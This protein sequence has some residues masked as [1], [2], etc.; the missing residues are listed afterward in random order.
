M[1]GFFPRLFI[2]GW[3]VLAVAPAAQAQ[4]KLP[5][6]VKIPPAVKAFLPKSE[7]A[8]SEKEAAEGLKE[9]LVQGIRSGVDVLSA[10][11]GF[12]KSDLYRLGLPS[13]VRDLEEKINSHPVLKAAFG[14]SLEKLKL[15]LNEAAEIAS[16]QAFPIFQSAVV[17]LSVSDAIGIVRGG[18]NAA[19]LYLK[20]QTEKELHAAFAPVIQAALDEVAIAQYWEPVAKGV[21]ANKRLLGR[22]ED[23]QTDLVLHVNQQATQALF[24]EIEKEEKSIRENPLR[25]TSALLKKIFG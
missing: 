9:A 2:L 1:M 18:E 19:T 5:P 3:M 14:S 11:G 25:R 21:N 6:G 12:S 16:K 4:I 23:I 22:T 7:I 15:K 17:K 13:E 8:F 24:S 10:E 20:N